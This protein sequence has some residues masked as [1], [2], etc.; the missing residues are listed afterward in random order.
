MTRINNAYTLCLLLQVVE[1]VLVEV[2]GG[3]VQHGQVI[4]QVAR[5]ATGKPDLPVTRLA[6]QL[7][8][9]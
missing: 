4:T 7:P 3:A 5:I 9:Q 6:V 1:A 2:E 8:G